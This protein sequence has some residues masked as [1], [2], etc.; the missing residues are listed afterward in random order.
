MPSMWTRKIS[1][2]QLRRKV[3]SQGCCKG[4]RD[5]AEADRLKVGGEGGRDVNEAKD[6]GWRE[7]CNRQQIW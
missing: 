4:R 6:A 5:R 2:R 3:L 7:R 1:L